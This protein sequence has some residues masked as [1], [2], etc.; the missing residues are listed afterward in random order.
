V[1]DLLC[2]CGCGGA[3]HGA[4]VAGLRVTVR[5]AGPGPESEPVTLA[6]AKLHLRVE[7]ALTLEDGLIQTYLTAA[8]EGIEQY[9]ERT[10]APR[11]LEAR[12]GPV[13]GPWPLPV[14]AG[15]VQDVTAVES[16][17]TDGTV[18]ALTGWRFDP[19]AVVVWPSTDG[20]PAAPTAVAITYDAGPVVCPEPIRQGILL[21]LAQYY[22]HRAGL[23]VGS[24]SVTLPYAVEWL[25]SP[26]RAST[27][28]V[29]A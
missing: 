3:L 27:G 17:A 2:S 21:L 29:L 18:A 9:T 8:R 15:P 26:Y 24:G 1:A 28:V 7:P 4:S 14:P 25:L 6:E 5:A 19:V 22:D 10:W 16:I 20:W 12:Y 11:P 23:H 13:P